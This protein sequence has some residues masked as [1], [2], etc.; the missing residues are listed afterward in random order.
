MNDYWLGMGVGGIIGMLVTSAFWICLPDIL[1]FL[2]GIQNNR[3]TKKAMKRIDFRKMPDPPDE[4]IEQRLYKPK[5]T[6]A[7]ISKGALGRRHPKS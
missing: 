4:G 5:G 1:D 6:P 7:Q 3:E 2:Q